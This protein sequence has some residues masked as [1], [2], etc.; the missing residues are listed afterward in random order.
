MLV[1]CLKKVKNSL[2]L[3]HQ[4]SKGLLLVSF[5]S[6]QPLVLNVVLGIHLTSLISLSQWGQPVS[7]QQ[8]A[9]L[10]PALL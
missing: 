3:L 2:Q 1:Q 9:A 4:I 5:C 6:L 10:D 7:S 8:E